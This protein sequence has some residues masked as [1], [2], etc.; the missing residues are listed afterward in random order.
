M[1]KDLQRSHFVSFHNTYRK[2]YAVTSHL[3]SLIAS[4][5]RSFQ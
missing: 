1:T 2:R 3:M 4:L 5:V